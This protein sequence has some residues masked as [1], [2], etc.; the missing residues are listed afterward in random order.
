[1]AT[2]DIAKRT[3]TRPTWAEVSLSALR[4]NYR[5]VAKYVGSGV[6]VCAVVK[7]YGY[8]H[9]A[10]ECARVLEEEG[11][12]WLGVTSLDEAIP[13]REE[14]IATRILLMTGFWRGEEEEI[15]RLD[16]TATVWEIGHIE[17]LE[18]A[19]ARLGVPQHAIHL[20]LDSGMG[21]LGAT[22]EEL[23]RICEALKASP[24]LKLEGFATHLASSEVLD[25]PSV[26]EQLKV[27]ADARRVLREY[28]FEPALVHAANTSAVISHHESWNTMVRPGLALYGYHLPFERAG[29]VVSGSGL[30]L[31]VKPVLTWKTRILSLREMRAGQA[32]GY[33]GTYVTRAPS[34]IAILP[35]GYADGLNRGLSGGGRVIVREH[36]APIVGR[37]SMD[38]TTV[39][40]TGIPGVEVADEVVLL[41]SHD[42]L[43]ADAREHAELANTIPYEILCAISKRVP[44]RYCT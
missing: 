43:S 29:R 37:I 7:A 8:G 13:L 36:Y 30:R 5:T 41:G 2:I 24:H 44:R 4:Q 35:V 17:L 23:P 9:G 12:T 18:R 19:A 26:S 14:G 31:S 1:M 28:G 38:L 20:K 42:G 27:F 34:R 32:L 16:L 15:V 10:V 39:D 25:A 22:P 6:T 3:A 40:V 11:A 33:G 21:R